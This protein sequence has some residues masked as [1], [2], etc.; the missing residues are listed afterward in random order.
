MQWCHACRV[1]TELDVARA[2]EGGVAE[3]FISS[4]KFD[5]ED[6]ITRHLLPP[7]QGHVSQSGN[8]FDETVNIGVRSRTGRNLKL[9]FDQTRL[10]WVKNFSRQNSIFLNFKKISFFFGLYSS[11]HESETFPKG[12][13]SS[14]ENGKIV[15]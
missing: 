8:T 6:E 9:L 15:S 11:R 7:S 4:V 3:N 14:L 13:S 5:C 2:F 12:P 10:Y 1:P